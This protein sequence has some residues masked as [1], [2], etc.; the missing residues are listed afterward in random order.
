MRYEDF[1]GGGVMGIVGLS[2]RSK[3]V[4]QCSGGAMDR[5]QI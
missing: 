2:A 5:C 1:K 4:G 3:L